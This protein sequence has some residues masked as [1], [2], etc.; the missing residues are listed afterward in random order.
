ML[1]KQFPTK[2]FLTRQFHSHICI[3]VKKEAT[4]GGG[5]RQKQDNYSTEDL[6][7]RPKVMLSLKE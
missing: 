4:E 1:L 5:A 6:K 2:P 7:K 3:E